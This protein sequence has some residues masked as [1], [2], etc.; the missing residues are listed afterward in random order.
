MQTPKIY[1]TIV[2]QYTSFLPFL[3]VAALLLLILI[4]IAL[5]ILLALLIDFVHTQKEV[6]GVSNHQR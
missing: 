3:I 1:P 6:Q 5:Q 4:L 2:M